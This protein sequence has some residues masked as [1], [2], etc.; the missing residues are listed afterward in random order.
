MNV[1][2][3]ENAFVILDGKNRYRI[4]EERF[5]D[6]RTTL[7]RVDYIP[8]YERSYMV[9]YFPKEIEQLMLDRLEEVCKH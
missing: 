7:I 2:M 8:I 4:N 6:K 9:S 5:S 3:K 1:L